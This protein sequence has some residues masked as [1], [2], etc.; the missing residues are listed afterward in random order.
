LLIKVVDKFVQDDVVL[1]VFE[2][3]CPLTVFKLLPNSDIL[4]EGFKPF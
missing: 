1:I 2:L 3:H 4:L